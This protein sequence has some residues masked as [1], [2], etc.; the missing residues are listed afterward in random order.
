MR[1]IYEGS[2]TTA[3]VHTNACARM[4]LQQIV[5][6][7][8]SHLP[9]RQGAQSVTMSKLYTVSLGN[10]EHNYTRWIAFRAPCLTLFSLKSV[11][12]TIQILY[13]RSES[14]SFQRATREGSAVLWFI[15]TGRK[16]AAGSEALW[17][18]SLTQWAVSKLSVTMSSESM[19]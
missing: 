12:L 6:D 14:I 2:V 10:N 18:L 7:C 9:N 13:R 19:R 1:D 15:W 5:A 16:A 11:N 3:L 4:I 8:N 17:V